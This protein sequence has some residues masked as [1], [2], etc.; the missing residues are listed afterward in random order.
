MVVVVVVVRTAFVGSDYM[1]VEGESFSM[2]SR[3]QCI[4]LLIGNKVHMQSKIP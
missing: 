3:T 1:V 4:D 2:S